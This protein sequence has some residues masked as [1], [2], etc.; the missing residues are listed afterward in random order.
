MQEGAATR[1]QPMPPNG[2]ARTDGDGI[3]RR[4]SPRSPVQNGQCWFGLSKGCGGLGCVGQDSTAID[5]WRCPGAAHR[6]GAGRAE[7]LGQPTDA[8]GIGRHL[9]ARRCQALIAWLFSAA[10]SGGAAL[11]ELGIQPAKDVGLVDWRS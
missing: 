8:C 4:V 10:G 7:Q 2:T 6:A 3:R 1:A 9:R 11:Q 5:I